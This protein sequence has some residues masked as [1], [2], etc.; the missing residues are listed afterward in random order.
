MRRLY[1]QPWCTTLGQVL[2]WEVAGKV[3]WV[4]TGVNVLCLYNNTAYIRYTNYAVH[5]T[6]NAV[7]GF[8]MSD[9]AEVRGDALYRCGSGQHLYKKVVFI[10]EN[11]FY[12]LKT[13]EI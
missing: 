2:G 12:L 11:V 4:P 3:L 13:R 7:Q 8:S 6:Q 5:N 10:V 1:L 9:A